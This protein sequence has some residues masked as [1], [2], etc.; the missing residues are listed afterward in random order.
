MSNVFTIIKSIYY[1]FFK[2]KTRHQLMDKVV[3]FLL[4]NEGFMKKR[5]MIA[6][7]KNS[8]D[9]AV[10]Y[11]K[12]I[13]KEKLTENEYKLLKFDHSYLKA[14]KEAGCYHHEIDV[15]GPE[16]IVLKFYEIME[17]I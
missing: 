6:V 16:E 11:L 14:F 12:D 10:E 17:N 8:E 15:T 1:N 4:S 2:I 5:F 7:F 3:C 13:A 9:H